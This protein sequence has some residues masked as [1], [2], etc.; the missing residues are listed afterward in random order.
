MSSSWVLLGRSET[1][2]CPR[3]SGGRSSGS[4]PGAGEPVGQPEERLVGAGQLGRASGAG[5]LN[6]KLL[7]AAHH[8]T[9]GQSR[10][11][12]RAAIS[13]LVKAVRSW[14]ADARQPLGSISRP[15]PIPGIR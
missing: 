13:T 12:D 1:V 9:P 7:I 6:R 8:R 2:R 11:T 3:G 14:P 4:R 15:A 10:R 5:W